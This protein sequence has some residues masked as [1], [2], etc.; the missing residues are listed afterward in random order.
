MDKKILFLILLGVLGCPLGFVLAANLGNYGS[1]I[2]LINIIPNIETTVWIIFGAI[3]IV[4]F[5]IAGVLFLTSQGSPEK[6]K[7]A[8]SAF[9]WGV[10]GVV[11]GIVA[12]SILTIVSNFI[13]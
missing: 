8:R 6:L 13:R 11:V 5:V 12:Y 3:V 10:V 4:C 1:N 9:I 7:T 2:D